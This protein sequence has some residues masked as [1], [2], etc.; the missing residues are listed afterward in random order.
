MFRYEQIGLF[1]NLRLIFNLDLVKNTI[2]LNQVN[3]VRYGF[4]RDTDWIYQGH[5][6][7]LN[8]NYDFKMI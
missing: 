4:D 2:F 6:G 5:I 3:F 8:I 7:K 1:I